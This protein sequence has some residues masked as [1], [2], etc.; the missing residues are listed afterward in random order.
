MIQLRLDDHPLLSNKDGCRIC[1]KDHCLLG[2]R[3]SAF[4]HYRWDR[5]E[6][7]CCVCYEEEED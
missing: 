3:L 5:S 1:G 7:I 4:G 2:C 6:T